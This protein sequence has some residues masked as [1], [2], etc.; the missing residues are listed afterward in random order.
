MALGNNW[1]DYAD[2]YLVVR[3]IG[4][5][6]AIKMSRIWQRCSAS[7]SR[8]Q[9]NGLAAETVFNLTLNRSSKATLSN[10]FQSRQQSQ[11]TLV[12]LR[13]FETLLG[14]TV[15]KSDCAFAV[16]VHKPVYPACKIP[17]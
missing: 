17:G 10:H 4:I 6:E 7:R 3:L 13:I 9:S 15:P 14:A 12:S 1:V 16:Y 11:A 5:T 8:R 2:D